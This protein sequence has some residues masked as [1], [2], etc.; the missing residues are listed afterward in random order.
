MRTAS[1]LRKDKVE[2]ANLVGSKWIGWSTFVGDRMM[3]EFVDK[4]HCVYTSAAKKFKMTYTVTGGKIF[5]SNIEGPFEL[6][7]RVLF[8]NGIPSFEKAA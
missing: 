2:P 8:N 7:G 5:I 4:T 6:D 1:L 3:V